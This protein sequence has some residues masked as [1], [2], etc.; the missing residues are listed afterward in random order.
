MTMDDRNDIGVFATTLINEVTNMLNHY[1]HLLAALMILI[2][3]TGCAVQPNDTISLQTSI[4]STA[5]LNPD[6]N[7]RP[8]P[9]VLTLYQLKNS[10]AFNEANFFALYNNA[11]EILGSTLIDK[12]SIE[13]PP[14]QARQVDLDISNKTRYIGI[15][16]AYRDPNNSKWR[17]I[18]QIPYDSKKMKINLQLQARQLVI[19][20][21]KKGSA[22]VGNSCLF[23]S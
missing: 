14:N 19:T 16:A 13:M 5:T 21:A 12:E 23:Y 9:I 22:C 4:Q 15:I 1:K 10:L 8:S 17:R 18:V 3:Q 7:N 2:I 6:I 11:Q 20:S